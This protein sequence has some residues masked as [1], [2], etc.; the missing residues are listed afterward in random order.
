VRLIA[1]P[2]LLDNTAAELEG[3]IYSSNSPPPISLVNPWAWQI[4]LNMSGESRSI[5]KRKLKSFVNGYKAYI[6]VRS[7]GI[8]KW[9][10]LRS[11]LAKVT[12]IKTK[13]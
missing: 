8:L 5:H 12:K 4:F 3:V 1:V 11:F 10:V 6:S 9:T 2:R 13:F 7:G